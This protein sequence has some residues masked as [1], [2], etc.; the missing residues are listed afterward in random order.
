MRAALLL[1][2]ALLVGCRDREVHGTAGPP[3]PPTARTAA[4]PA[5]PRPVQL[6]AGSCCCEA[7]LRGDRVIRVIAD[8]RCLETMSG[9]CVPAERCWLPDPPQVSG[10]EPPPAALAPATVR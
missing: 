1:T 4:A 5:A 10:Q 7:E 3:A 2:I 8:A 6:P 9:Q